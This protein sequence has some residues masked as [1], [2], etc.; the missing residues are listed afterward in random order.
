MPP[1]SVA[2]MFSLAALTFDEVL[3]EAA[4]LVAGI[5]IVMLLMV[6]IIEVR[7]TA[8]FDDYLR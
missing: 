3:S 7:L 2:I 8:I 5:S 1:S 6:S 4:K